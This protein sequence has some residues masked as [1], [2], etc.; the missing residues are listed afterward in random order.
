[1]EDQFLQR[2]LH[3]AKLQLKIGPLFLLVVVLYLVSQF[4]VFHDLGIAGIFIPFTGFIFFGGLRDYINLIKFEK[5]VNLSFPGP[6]SFSELLRKSTFTSSY[7]DIYIYHH[8]LF[9]LGKRTIFV[10]D[11]NQLSY[12]RIDYE[13]A[14]ALSWVDLVIQDRANQIKK[15]EIPHSRDFGLDPSGRQRIESD[16]RMLQDYLDL[17]YP[18]ILKKKIPTSTA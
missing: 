4:T 1:M 17:H 14:A 6:F 10:E 16:I 13:S 3:K 12:I 5:K 11:L 9:L 18:L 2:K 15:W 7:L 8:H